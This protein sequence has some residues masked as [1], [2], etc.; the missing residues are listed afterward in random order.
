MNIPIELNDM[1]LKG[2]ATLALST[3]CQNNNIVFDNLRAFLRKYKGILIGSAASHCFYGNDYNDVDIFIEHHDFKRD[4]VL[5]AD[6]KKLILYQAIPRRIVRSHNKLGIIDLSIFKEDVKENS[7]KYV[8][9]E[10]TRVMFDG[11]NWEFPDNGGGRGGGIFKCLETKETKVLYVKD[12]L[13][14]IIYSEM[15]IDHIKT[16]VDKMILPMF[17]ISSVTTVCGKVCVEYYKKFRNYYSEI[18]IEPRYIGCDDYY[19]LPMPKKVLSSEIIENIENRMMI[20]NMCK[21]YD[22]IH[23]LQNI[24]TEIFSN[25]VFDILITHTEKKNN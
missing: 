22:E 18:R 2:R 16:Q 15:V 6:L 10:C 7:R 21:V 13:L 24:E 23:K 11:D 12:N 1:V 17:D 25:A 14:N 9:I 3:V 20:Y 19:E 8:D 4:A 5:V